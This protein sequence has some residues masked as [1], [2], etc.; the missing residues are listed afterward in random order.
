MFFEGA[1]RLIALGASIPHLRDGDPSRIIVEAY[2]GVLARQAIGR[3]AYKNDTRKKQT[4]EQ[5]EARSDLLAALVNGELRDRYG[6]TVEA[7]QDLCEDPGADHLDALLCAVQ[8]AWAWKNRAHA[9]GAPD[10]IDP[11]EGWIADPSLRAV[12]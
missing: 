1:P 6:F 9:F 5:R 3:R 4:V 8:A 11:L 12:K 2:P 7:R 10:Q